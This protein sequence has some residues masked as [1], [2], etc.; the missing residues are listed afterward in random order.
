MISKAEI[1][2]PADVRTY[3]QHLLQLG[4]P[5]QDDLPELLVPGSDALADFPR[6]MR[7]Y[8]GRAR[9]W[10]EAAVR[11]T[12]TWMPRRC[13]GLTRT[14]K[15]MSDIVAHDISTKPAKRRRRRR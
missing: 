14:S 3:H 11:R 5:R 8:D 9:R 6:M 10:N 1:D 7:S 2:T 13:S 15:R 12:S 4:A